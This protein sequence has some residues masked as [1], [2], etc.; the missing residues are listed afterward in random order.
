MLVRTALGLPIAL[1]LMVASVLGYSSLPVFVFRAGG[2]DSPFLF[3]FLWR[4]FMLSGVLVLLLVFR[5]WLLL[6]PV[7]LAGG[8]APAVGLARPGPVR[9]LPG[10]WGLLPRDA[11]GGP[12]PGRWGLSTTSLIVLLALSHRGTGAYRRFTPALLGLLLMGAA[13]YGLVVLSQEGRVALPDDGLRFLLGLLLVLGAAFLISLNAYGMRWGRDLALGLGC[14]TPWEMSFGSV[15][16]AAVG[17]VFS[18]PFSL[19]VGWGAGESWLSSRDVLLCFLGAF[20]VIAVCTVCWRLAN[21]LTSN[22]GINA[23]SYLIPVLAL[24]WLFILG[25]THVA[26]VDWLLVGVGLVVGCNV[27]VHFRSSH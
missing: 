13:G 23:V 6:S 1:L 5:R 18:L 17:A 4:V 12:Q 14:S 19:L 9:V 26:R 22:L 11:P 7:L 25:E 16:G 15:L 20:G 24:G 3:N 2:F 8:P 10:P 27:L 21:L